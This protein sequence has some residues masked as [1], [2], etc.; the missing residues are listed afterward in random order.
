VLPAGPPCLD[1]SEKAKPPGQQAR[2]VVEREDLTF[3]D[4]LP[5]DR[6]HD[7][8]AFEVTFAVI[9]RSSRDSPLTL[10]F[11]SVV[12]LRGAAMRLRAFGFRVSV[13]EVHEQS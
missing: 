8:A 12:S 11:F 5:A 9:T 6:P 3:A 10:P 7:P 13:A 2:D 4:V 1:L